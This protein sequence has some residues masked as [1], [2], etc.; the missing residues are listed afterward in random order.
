MID[1]VAQE[2]LMRVVMKEEDIAIKVKEVS[3]QDE[4]EICKKIRKSVFTDEQGIDTKIDIDKYDN[5]NN[6]TVHF[7]I[8]LNGEAIGTSRYIKLSNE[9]V[10]LQRL[11]IKKEFRNKG[12]ASQLIKFMEEYAKKREIDYLELHA[13]YYAK[14]FYSKLGYLPI[15]EKYI[16]KETGI[17][18]INMSKKLV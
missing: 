4:L 18:H 13:Q 9:K 6:D 10:Q 3:T 14:E 2:S 17:E 8:Y 15:S 1:K 12:Y 16:E 11:A 5:F 7:L